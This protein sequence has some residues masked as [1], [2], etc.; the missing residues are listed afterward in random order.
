MCKV[1]ELKLLTIKQILSIRWVSSSLRS[2]SAVWEDYEALVLKMTAAE[3]R[4]TDTCPK[5]YTRRLFQLNFY[6]IE[7]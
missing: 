3:T 4:K 5:V 7:D 2:V 1:A 6:W